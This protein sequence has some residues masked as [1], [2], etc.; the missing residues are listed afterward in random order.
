MTSEISGELDFR[1]QFL[2]QIGPVFQ[3][4]SVSS[5]R[6]MPPVDGGIDMNCT[7]ELEASQAQLARVKVKIDD[8]FNNEPISLPSGVK[9]TLSGTINLIQQTENDKI[10]SPKVTQ[11]SSFLV[12]A[13]A[14]LFSSFTAFPV[15]GKIIAPLAGLLKELQLTLAKVNS[16]STNVNFRRIQVDDDSC[17][18]LADLYR[19]VV[20]ESSMMKPILPTSASPEVERLIAES[21]LVLSS[22]RKS[23]IPGSNQD[24]LSTST[25]YSLALLDHYR[26]ELLSISQDG[27][28]QQFTAG[29]LGL[30]VGISNALR[31][32]LHVTSHVDG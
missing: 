13:L 27:K 24:Q 5:S 9:D 10:P 16:C 3:A 26:R 1:H 15:F 18:T 8:F 22:M 19:S 4:K 30:V 28:L 6:A 17:D 14:T 31:A 20:D 7:A 25:D 2:L 12:T 32:C 11:A 29:Y 23:F 21:M